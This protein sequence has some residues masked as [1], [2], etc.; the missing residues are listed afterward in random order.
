MGDKP[1]VLGARD[2]VVAAAKVTASVV[3]ATIGT[4][5]RDTTVAGAAVTAGVPVTV[6][7]RDTVS[8]GVGARDAAGAGS[9]AQN[10]AVS[11][12]GCWG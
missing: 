3:A 6:S 2:T 4:G 12:C 5:V 11:V 7:A 1:A 10:I 9:G 8:V